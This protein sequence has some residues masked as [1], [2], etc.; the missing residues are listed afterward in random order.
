[1]AIALIFI[2]I[3]GISTVYRA[4]PYTI[5][6]KHWGSRVHRCDF[7]VDTAAGRAVLDGADIYQAHNIR[8][9]YYIYPPLF[10]IGMVPFALVPTF[11]ASLA[12]YILSVVLVARTVRMCVTLVSGALDFNGDLLWLYALPPLLVLF[13]LMSALARGQTSPVLLWLVTAG[14][15]YGWKGHDWRGGI[16]FAGGIVLKVFPVV[17]L[18]YFVWRKRWR[19]VLVTLTA[20]AIGAF[21]IPAAVFGWQR[22]VDYLREWVDVIGKPALEAESERADNPLYGQ[23]LSSQLP[24][25][26]SLSAVLTRLTGNAQARW[27]GI[28]FGVIMAGIILVVGGKIHPGSEIHI[29]SA[30]VVWM[31]LIPPVSWA[32][33]F[34]LLLLPLTALVTAAIESA[35]EPVRNVARGALAFFALLALGLS[36]SRA[37]QAYGPLCWGTLALWAALVVCAR[38][39]RASSIQR[40]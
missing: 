25:N 19:F 13:P 14:L 10:A 11:W 40:E 24:R 36:G 16:C 38:A 5:G 15:F 31:V 30:A 39:G 7:T 8:G 9:W 17:L 26:Q 1:M 34:M 20:T 6:G 23:L 3:L 32:H 22:N 29:L 4:G 21:I 2:V 12:W 33:Y 28:G 35:R 37:A 18:A 27:A